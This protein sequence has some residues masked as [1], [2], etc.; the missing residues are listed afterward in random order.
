MS[1]TADKPA[2]AHDGSD[3]SG[4]QAHEAA[5]RSPGEDVGAARATRQRRRVVLVNDEFRIVDTEVGANGGMVHPPESE[6]RS[7]RRSPKTTSEAEAEDQNQ[8]LTRS[9]SSR[10]IQEGT[11]EL[12]DTG[13]CPCHTATHACASLPCFA[14]SSALHERTSGWHHSR[15]A[16]PKEWLRGALFTVCNRGQASNTSAFA[17]L[18]RHQ[19]CRRHRHMLVLVLVL[20]HPSRYVC[21]Q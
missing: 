18:Y 6:R 20:V 2:E 16:T 15:T 9:G 14:Q 11:D 17:R 8:R 1:P 13:V 5:Q 4:T 10:H 19:L 3:T 12:E 7:S 21:Q